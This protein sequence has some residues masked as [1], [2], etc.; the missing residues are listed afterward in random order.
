MPS[1]DECFG[2]I[3]LNIQ[4]GYREGEQHSLVPSS[5]AEMGRLLFT[6]LDVSTSAYHGNN[7]FLKG[8]LLLV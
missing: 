5:I 6:S 4:Q 2:N 3:F 1:D 8:N 7:G